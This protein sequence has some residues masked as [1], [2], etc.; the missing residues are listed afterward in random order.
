MKVWQTGR[1]TGAIA[2]LRC[3][4]SSLPIAWLTLT[5]ILLISASPIARRVSG[6]LLRP[7]NASHT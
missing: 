1:C 3:C 5:A 2:S 6:K 4:W 7:E